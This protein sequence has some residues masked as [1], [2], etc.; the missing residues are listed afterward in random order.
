MCRSKRIDEKINVFEIVIEL[1]KRGYTF[2]EAL[3]MIGI[4]ENVNI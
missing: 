2:T 3:K 1:I 4:K